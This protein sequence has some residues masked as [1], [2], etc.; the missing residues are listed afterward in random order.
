MDQIS[1]L[2]GYYG[3]NLS[4]NLTIFLCESVKM[5]LWPL[6]TIDVAQFLISV[7]QRWLIDP[8]GSR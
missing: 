1:I 7:P 4:V 5:S 3:V 2:L 8:P 6:L